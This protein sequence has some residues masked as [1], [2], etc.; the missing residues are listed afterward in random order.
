MATATPSLETPLPSKTKQ[1][2]ETLTHLSQGSE[3]AE[4]P[5]EEKLTPE[6]KAGRKFATDLKDLTASMAKMAAGLKAKYGDEKVQGAYRAEFLPLFRESKELFARQGRRDGGLTWDRWFRKNRPLFK[7][8]KATANRWLADESMQAAPT[9]PHLGEIRIVGGRVGWIV[10]FPEQEPGKP[11]QMSVKFNDAPD[12][13]P[14]SIVLGPQKKLQLD[15]LAD[16]IYA[17]SD[18]GWCLYSN[19]QHKLVPF[20][21]AAKVKADKVAAEAKDK[22]AEDKAKAA[23]IVADL[24]EARKKSTPADTALSVLTGKKD[25]EKAA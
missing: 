6:Q 25:A 12:K 5:T 8:S 20:P 9:L 2:K 4:N 19:T 15:E 7:V 11:R 1:P 13:D 24:K 18:G 21:A 14:E 3:H 16:I 10:G 17:K 23:K 22:A